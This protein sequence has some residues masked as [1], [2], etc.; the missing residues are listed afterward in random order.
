MRCRRAPKAPYRRVVL[1]IVLEFTGNLRWAERLTSASIS[2][3]LVRFIPL[4]QFRYRIALRL[5]MRVVLPSA[6][7]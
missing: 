6:D 2:L 4:G 1:P 3:S 5:L 7:Q